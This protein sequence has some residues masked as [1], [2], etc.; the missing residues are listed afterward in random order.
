MNLEVPGPG[1][2]R[3]CMQTSMKYS[4]S[5]SIEAD[6]GTIHGFGHSQYVGFV[7]SRSESATGPESIVLRF[8]VAEVRIVGTGL[9]EIEEALADGGLK[10]LRP[11]PATLARAVQ[12]KP[13]ITSITVTWE[14]KEAA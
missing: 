3:H 9:A 5:V 10:R 8:A 2:R 13:L 7:R 1:E 6:D 11:V 12:L 14:K 4:S